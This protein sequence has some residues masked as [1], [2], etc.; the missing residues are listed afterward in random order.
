MATLMGR[1]GVYI[2]CMA[3]QKAIWMYEVGRYGR[4]ND[5]WWSEITAQTFIDAC[6]D[7]HMEQH[8]REVYWCPKEERTSWKRI[9]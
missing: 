9:A 4:R 3:R 6:E 8:A 5:P 2:P 7:S 1:G